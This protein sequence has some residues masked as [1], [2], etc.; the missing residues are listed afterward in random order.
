MRLEIPYIKQKR[1]Y[2]CGPASLGMALSFLGHIKSQ[3]K[4]T[5]AMKTS[6]GKGTP[7]WSMIN[8]ARK[9]GFYVYVNEGANLDELKYYLAQ[10]FPVIVNYNEPS[11]N[12]SHFSVVLGFGRITGTIIMNDPWNGKDFRLRE[13]EFLKRWYSLGHKHNNWLMVVSKDPFKLGKQ[14]TP[15]SREQVRLGEPSTP[16]K[17]DSE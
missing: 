15:L 2:T 6:K 10:G 12:E 9:E 5:R 16:Q 7:N 4:L 1:D 17:T 13:D 3:T 11:G 8:G 14:F